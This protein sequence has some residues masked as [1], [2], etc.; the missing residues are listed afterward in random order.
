MFAGF[1]CELQF[2]ELWMYTTAE[3]YFMLDGV[4]SWV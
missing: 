1:E 3:P 2:Y 4:G